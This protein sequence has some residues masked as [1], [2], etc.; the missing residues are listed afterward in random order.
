MARPMLLSDRVLFLDG[1]A[2]IIDKP[3]GL[4]VDTPRDKSVSVE[5]HLKMLTFGFARHPLPVHRLDRDTSGCLL[6]AR[7]PKAHKRFAAAF[8]AGAV[9]KTY[10]AI[11]DGVPATSDGT[12]DMPL[13]KTS[14]AKDGWRI[15]PDPKGKRA[16]THW[17]ILAEL[18]FPKE[19]LMAAVFGQRL[20]ELL[21]RR[22]PGARPQSL[23]ATAARR[24]G[25]C[26]GCG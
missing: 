5:S 2:I 11:L 3:A 12:V 22:F 7:N 13:G 25:R 24:R 26:D 1:E 18:H 14:T 15:V 20:A 16:V 9:A 8:E 21:D 6:L 23:R 19:R 17:R 4:P 10:L